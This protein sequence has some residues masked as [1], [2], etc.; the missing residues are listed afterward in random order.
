MSPEE[1]GYLS[2]T[3]YKDYKESWEKVRLQ[4]H[5]ILASQSAKPLKPTDIMKFDWDNET[6]SKD[7]KAVE[8]P[9]ETRR[10]IRD[11]Y[12]LK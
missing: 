4:N 5:A 10:R 12:K 7:E 3:F 9:D 6:G 2:T 8:N 11:K 1:V